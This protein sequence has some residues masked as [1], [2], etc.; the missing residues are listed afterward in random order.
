MNLNE[1]PGTM[2]APRLSGRKDGLKARFRIAFTC[3]PGG[4]AHREL[5]RL[6]PEVEAMRRAQPM[7]H[8]GPED[9]A[10]DTTRPQGGVSLE[11]ESSR[12]RNVP[13]TV[14]MHALPA[15]SREQDAPPLVRG[16]CG[17]GNKAEVSVAGDYPR[18]YL[19]LVVDAALLPDVS[20]ADASEWDDRECWV[21]LV[22]TQAELPLGE[23]APKKRG[24]KK[25]AQAQLE[26]VPA[27]S[28]TEPTPPV[29]GPVL[30]VFRARFPSWPVPRWTLV[31][32]LQAIDR[33]VLAE[34][35]RE[36]GVIELRDG[37]EASE[38]AAQVAGLLPASD[39]PRTVANAACG[40]ALR[41]L[42]TRVEQVTAAWPAPADVVRNA[43]QSLERGEMLD[44]HVELAGGPAPDGADLVDLL[45]GLVPVAEEP[46]ASAA[47]RPPAPS[48][49]AALGAWRTLAGAVLIST[50]KR[51]GLQGALARC[52][53]AVDDYFD[54]D[55]TKA[56][57]WAQP[58]L[59]AEPCWCAVF[60]TDGGP[61]C[62][63]GWVA[64]PIVATPEESAEPE[65]PAGAT[66]EGWAAA[67]SASETASAPVVEWQPLGAFELRRMDQQSRED[68][69][70]ALTA[71]LAGLDVGQLQAQYRS[72]TGGPATV[73][74]P[75]YLREQIAAHVRGRGIR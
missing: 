38:L 2:A 61:D 7:Q 22:E 58:S 45:A 64:V 29:G 24:R 12:L 34:L 1:A 42:R 39:D 27:P 70:T 33:V 40:P 10:E 56:I 49:D 50:S 46:A 20:F 30:D 41:I 25:K 65:L 16:T 53:G 13:H 55:Q 28:A 23:A 8:E 62:P 18:L 60:W 71:Y 74:S 21:T 69:A 67:V 37:V 59:N 32:A 72:V 48:K 57:A 3:E 31:E 43:L 47:V 51:L 9:D 11:V 36:L 52:A 44:L 5:V 17:L 19:V 75:V 54:D 4:A 63:K 26:L 66:A 68:K 73:T 15:E 14:T 6:L 35:L